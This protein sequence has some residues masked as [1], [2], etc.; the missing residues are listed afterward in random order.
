MT[1]KYET[2]LVP[3]V[4]KISTNN[5]SCLPNH[6]KAFLILAGGLVQL[7]P[8][9]THFWEGA[10]KAKLGSK[11]TP[12]LPPPSSHSLGWAEFAHGEKKKKIREISELEEVKRNDNQNR[13]F[14]LSLA[15]L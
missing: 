5:E 15:T 1:H 4:V 11:A 10:G 9:L 12:A 6:T 13:M 8:Q 14:L 7:H 3:M 2:P